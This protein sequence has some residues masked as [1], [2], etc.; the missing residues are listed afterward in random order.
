L[1]EL[2][3]GKPLSPERT[4]KLALALATVFLSL[5]QLVWT[6]WRQLNGRSVYRKEAEFGKLA[7][8]YLG[9]DGEVSSEQVRQPLERTR[10]LIAALLGAMGRSGANFARRHSADLAPE[11][12]EN[13]ARQEKK[14]FESLDAASW[15]KYRELYKEYAT[16]QTLESQ[17][18]Q[19]FVK[20]AEELLRGVSR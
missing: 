17:L 7:G 11:S 18:Q 8:P 16:E 19:E 1:L 14:A 5:D 15:R 20:A 10:R 12:I 13:A 4:P 6:L 2:D 3:A 9:G